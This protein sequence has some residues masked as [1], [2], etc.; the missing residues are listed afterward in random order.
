MQLS[1]NT[2]FI[3]GIDTHIGKSYVTGYLADQLLQQHCQVITQKLVQ[4][5][6]EQVS[7]DIQ[8]HRQLMGGVWYPE[9]TLKWTMPVILPYPASPH[10][11]SQLANQPIDLEYIHQCT[12]NLQQRYDYVLI[13]G[14]GGLYV[15]LIADQDP[16]YYMIDYIQQ[17][18][19]PVILVTSGR[20]GSI[21]HTLLSLQTLKQYNIPVAMLAY[22]QYADIQDPIISNETKCYLQHYLQCYSPQTQWVDI[23]SLSVI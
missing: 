5:G 8:L 16:H 23:P 22:N 2:Y 17:H 11:A 15:P 12:L 14:A 10:L 1:P 20:L 4:T 3:T 18:H 19:Y 13:E 21:N 7:E 9:D 6:N